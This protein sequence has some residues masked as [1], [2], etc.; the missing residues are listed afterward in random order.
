MH[1][2]WSNA[3]ALEEKLRGVTPGEAL[4]KRWT[5][6]RNSLLHS[7]GRISRGSLHL[8]YFVEWFAG[9]WYPTLSFAPSFSPLSARPVNV[10]PFVSTPIFPPF[11]TRV[12]R[13]CFYFAAGLADGTMKYVKECVH[14]V[15]TSFT[16]SQTE[17]TR[18]R[19]NK[20]RSRNLFPGQW[21]EMAAPI[22]LLYNLNRYRNR[23]VD[24]PV[25]LFQIK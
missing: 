9:I 8:V 1:P 20:H 21:D 2:V 6:T 13:H 23:D 22:L 12:P 15:K 18:A 7:D 10:R 24:R 4:G 3:A 5:T 11:S 16:Y 19:E 14:E 25:F 17:D